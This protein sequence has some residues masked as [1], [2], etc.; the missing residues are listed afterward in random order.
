MGNNLSVSNALF[1][2][3]CPASVISLEATQTARKLGR[4]P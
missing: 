3:Y 4:Q 2:T 1:A